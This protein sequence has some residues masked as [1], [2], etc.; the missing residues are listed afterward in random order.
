MVW[1]TCFLGPVRGH[2]SELSLTPHTWSAPCLGHRHWPGCSCPQ[3]GPRQ[4]TAAAGLGPG[5]RW[6]GLT[7]LRCPG[8][9]AC[10]CETALPAAEPLP[11][12]FRLARETVAVERRLSPWSRGWRKK[13]IPLAQPWA[14]QLARKD[15]GT[16]AHRPEGTFLQGF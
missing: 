4:E 8:Q 12:G 15:A 6:L 1:G 3:E 16:W 14:S 13:P 11:T 9:T 10:T 5:E 7:R 2:F